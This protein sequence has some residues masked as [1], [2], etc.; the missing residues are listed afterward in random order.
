MKTIHLIIIG[1]L[2]L[3]LGAWFGKGLNTGSST[4]EK[5]GDISIIYEPPVPLPDFTLTDHNGKDFNQWGLSR[6]WTFIFFGYT[7]CP[8][9]CPMGLVDLDEVYSDL[10]AKGDLIEKR[11]RVDT[12]VLFVSVDP[13]RDTV[14]ALKDYV[15][16]FNKAFIGLTGN[17]EVIDTLAH[18]MG[19]AYRRVP[20]KDPD[21]DYYVDHSA[22]FLLIDPLGRLRASFPPPHDPAKVAEEFRRLRDKYTEECCR[23]SIEFNYISFGNDEDELDCDCIDGEVKCTDAEAEAEAKKL[24]CECDE[25][26]DLACEE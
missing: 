16:Y 6:K 18:P 9:V 4:K 15:P 19:V 1:I 13:A 24:D 21:G 11:F 8:D 26:G 7:F 14:D 23:T 10:A 20:G 17:L 25:D 22:S 2:L 5:G 12:Q 3:A